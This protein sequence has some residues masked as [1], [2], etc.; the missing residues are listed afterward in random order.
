MVDVDVPRD[1]TGG[2]NLNKVR[3]LEMRCE[4]MKHRKGRN[5]RTAE[6]R[7]LQAIG[8]VLCGPRHRRTKPETPGSNLLV[9]LLVT[10]NMQHEVMSTSDTVPE[11][12]KHSN[13]V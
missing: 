4:S 13:T 12:I 9:L 2:Y 8:D 10:R 5:A 11:T 3:N 7:T 1:Q 6:R